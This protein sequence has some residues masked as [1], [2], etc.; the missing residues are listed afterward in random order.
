MNLRQIPDVPFQVCVDIARIEEFAFLRR[1][2]QDFGITT[3]P[4]PA[5]EL[6]GIEPAGRC[7]EMLVGSERDIRFS[8]KLGL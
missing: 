4:N 5:E 6:L 1:G 8:G 7:A 3:P 2:I